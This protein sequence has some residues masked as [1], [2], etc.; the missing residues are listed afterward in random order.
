MLQKGDAVGVH[1]LCKYFISAPGSLK[2]SFSVAG[3]TCFLQIA[4]GCR[5][6]LKVMLGC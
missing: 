2:I 6:L 1:V 4:R 5:W 3:E